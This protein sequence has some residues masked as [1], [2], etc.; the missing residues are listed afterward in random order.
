MKRRRGGHSGHRMRGEK[1]PRRPSPQRSEKTRILIVC[2]GRET[3]PNYLH[4][5]RDEEAVRQYFI[6]EVRKGKGGSCLDVIQQAIAER[7]KAAARRKDFDE[8]W[9]VFDVEQASRREQVIDA[10]TLAGQHEIQLALSNPSFEC[11]LLAHFTRTK[12]SFAGADKVIEELNK[13]WRREFGQDYEK[14]DE[15]IYARLSARTQTALDNARKVRKQDWSS[16]SDIIDC[17]S[18]TEVYLLVERLLR[19]STGDKTVAL[20]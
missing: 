15:Q 19:S 16:S 3:E 20:P 13:Y 5:L 6:V 2:E 12:K 18:A 8:V 17:N 10:R 9:C 4:G 14:S 11:W 1:S 7:E